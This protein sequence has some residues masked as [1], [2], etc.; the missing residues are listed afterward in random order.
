ML[1]FVNKFLSQ[2]FSQFFLSGLT[3]TKHLKSVQAARKLSCSSRFVL[4]VQALKLIFASICKTT[5]DFL[6]YIW[7]IPVTLQT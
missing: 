7:Q 4:F 3:A 2:F 6:Q 5:H 1:N